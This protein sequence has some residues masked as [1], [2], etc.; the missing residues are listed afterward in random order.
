MKKTTAGL[1]PYIA[2]ALAL[3]VL[4]CILLI[5]SDPAPEEVCRWIGI[6]L[7]L[8]GVVKAAAFLFR[9]N[10]SSRNAIDLIVG[11]IQ[12]ACGAACIAKPDA[13]AGFFPIIAACLLGYGAIVLFAQ[14]SAVIDHDDNVFKLSLA[15]GMLCLTPTVLVLI[16]PGCLQDLA[17]PAAGVSMTAEG[18]FLLFAILKARKADSE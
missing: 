1:L 18:I 9:K 15:L 5:R 13:I 7:I 6:A 11:L 16:R 14:A 3:I 8:P 4:G 10:R 17:V 2:D 12:I